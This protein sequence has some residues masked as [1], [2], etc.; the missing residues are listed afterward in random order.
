MRVRRTA[1]AVVST[2][3]L[4]AG[5]CASRATT[6][7][8]GAPKG[9]RLY[10]VDGNMS[11][12]LGAALKTRGLISGMMGTTPLTPL[13]PDFKQRL[14]ATD[15]SLVDYTYAGEA[16][17]A[18]V[19]TA[20]AVQVAHTVDP[21]VV[22]KHING[23]TT[24]G[25]ECSSIKECLNAI[26]AGKGIAYRG[27]TVRTGFTDV[28]EPSTTSYGTLHFGPDDKIDNGKTEF[29]SAGDGNSATT[30]KPPAP[31]PTPTQSGGK[32][33]ETRETLKLGI[34]LAKTGGLARLTPPIFAG[35]HLA[36][37]EINALGGVLGRPI[38]YEDGDDGTDPVKAGAQLDKFIQEGIG[39]IIGPSTSGQSVAL[40]PKAVAANRILFSPSATSAVLTKAD[41]HGLYFRTAPSDSYQSQALADVIMRGGG[42]RVYIVGR[43]DAYGTGI[44]DGVTDD[45]VKV[46]IKKVDIGSMTYQ[47]DQKDFSDIV[48]SVKSFNPDSIV[49]AGYA[50]SAKVIEAM[51]GA[52]ITF[53]R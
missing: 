39:I 48:Q 45:L 8:D 43:S 12:S 36:I 46:G 44:R 6:P 25:V 22:A 13:S 51:T 47:E 7:G 33:R 2:A 16:Y 11:N 1:L 23:V 19:I 5:G 26:A 15:P 27:V 20:L 9:I 18:V 24:G 31:A 53:I 32:G 52:G 29:V 37:K 40:I 14:F 41:D 30:A 38:T 21:G 42:R 28:G 49:I 34:L 50:E 4:L 10:G 17:D 3:L 35:A